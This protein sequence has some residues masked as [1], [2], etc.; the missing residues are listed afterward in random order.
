VPAD[1]NKD[2]I[3]LEI[4]LNS[5]NTSPCGGAISALGRPKSDGGR[6]DSVASGGGARR[7]TT[8]W[9]ANKQLLRS[10]RL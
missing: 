10:E 3:A 8:T 9:F 7:A 2:L 5:E 4:D 6:R 1:Q